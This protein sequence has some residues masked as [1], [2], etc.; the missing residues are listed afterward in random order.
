VLSQQQERKHETLLGSGSLA[1]LT[2]EDLKPSKQVELI[3]S[4]GRNWWHHQDEAPGAGE[5]GRSQCSLR[6]LHIF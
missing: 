2:W 6:V 3:H 4:P 5:Q 1:W